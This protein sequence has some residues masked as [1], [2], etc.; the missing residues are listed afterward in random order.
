MKGFS[1]IYS[2]TRPNF[3]SK[4]KSKLL[5]IIAATLE[6]IINVSVLRLIFENSCPICQSSV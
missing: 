5:F 2:L 1:F 3:P 6:N 4:N